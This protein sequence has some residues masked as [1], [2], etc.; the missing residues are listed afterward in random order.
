LRGTQGSR[1]ILAMRF[2]P[3]KVPQPAPGRLGALLAQVGGASDDPVRAFEEGYAALVGRRHAIAFGGARSAFVM[4]VRAAGLPAGTR[5]LVPSYTAP[6]VPAMVR[7]AGL[8]P[9]AA[10][11]ERTSFNLDPDRLPEGPPGTLVVAVHTEGVPARVDRLAEVCAARRF[12]LA[13]DCAH[14]ALSSLGGRTVGTFGAAAWT[15]FGKGKQLN[16]L[17]G[18]LLLLDDDRVAARVRELRDALPALPGWAPLPGLALDVAMQ[19]ATSWP[20]REVTLRPLVTWPRL[21]LGVDVLT[22]L[23]EEGGTTGPLRP[24]RLCPVSARVG[25]AALT[26]LPAA[27]QRRRALADALRDRLAGR[28]RLQEPP[29][30]ADAAPLELAVAVPERDRVQDDL[31]AAGIDTQRTWMVDWVAREGGPSPDPEASRLE[32]EVLYLPVYPAL[33]LDEVSRVADRLLA[34][35]E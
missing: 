25:L 31:L 15:S 7:M 9:V 8:V 21:V 12:V 16:A 14:A 27:Q 24:S 3:R 11:I 13:E 32:R 28:V 29:P 18:G 33:S 6:V 1:N 5:A 17:G 30:G 19:V 20:T 22:R 26:G 34:S 10:P 2:I 35:L 23:F 4:W